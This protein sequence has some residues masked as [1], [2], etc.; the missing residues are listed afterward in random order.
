MNLLERPERDPAISPWFVC[1]TWEEATANGT[2]HF[3]AVVIGGMFGGYCA[4]RGRVV[5]VE[6]HGPAGLV[7]DDKVLGHE[8]GYE[9]TCHDRGH[10]RP[11]VRARPGDE[12]GQ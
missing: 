9:E 11:Q 8:L 10:S 1:N 7:V 3:D 4:D 6:R 5:V 12:E 2:R